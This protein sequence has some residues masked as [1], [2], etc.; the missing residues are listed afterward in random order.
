MTE[1]G[2]KWNAM[3]KMKRNSQMQENIT[4]MVPRKYG[5]KTCGIGKYA[6]GKSQKVSKCA[7]NAQDMCF[8]AIKVKP[9]VNIRNISK[10]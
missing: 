3:A 8:L 6:D 4:K 9:A 10:I 1:N 2:P 5:V 7:T